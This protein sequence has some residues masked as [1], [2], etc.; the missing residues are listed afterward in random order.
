[1]MKLTA[2][3][4]KGSNATPDFELSDAS[5]TFVLDSFVS[6]EEAQIHREGDD[7][8]MHLDDLKSI[9]TNN[10]VGELIS[11]PL[12]YSGPYRTSEGAPCWGA[13][14]VVHGSTEKVG[15]MLRY[16]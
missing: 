6:D 16:E 9:L 1:M 12:V 11:Y 4:V 3:F 14:V 5:G 13:L 7:F 10:Y 15:Y 2:T 8:Q